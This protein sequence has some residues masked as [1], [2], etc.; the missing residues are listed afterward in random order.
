MIKHASSSIETSSSSQAKKNIVVVRVKGIVYKA[1]LKVYYIDFV[2]QER[3][4]FFFLDIYSQSDSF[5]CKMMITEKRKT[6]K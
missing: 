5:A 1:Y 2:F 6:E 4:L 3:L